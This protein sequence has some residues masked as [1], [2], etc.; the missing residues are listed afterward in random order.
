MIKQ[1]SVVGGRVFTTPKRSDLCLL[2]YCNV[3]I[4]Q[5]IP[6]FSRICLISK[7]S[8]SVPLSYRLHFV[9]IAIQLAA[10]RQEEGVSWRKRK[11]P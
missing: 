7:R 6:K 5:I 2:F 4:I 10:G 8:D 9:L 1:T 11:V 3:K